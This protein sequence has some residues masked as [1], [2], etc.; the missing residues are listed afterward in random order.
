M[1]KNPYRG[2]RPG[3]KPRHKNNFKT[4]TINVSRYINKSITQEDEA[5]YQSKNSFA[6]F[7]F[8]PK[9]KQILDKI[10]Y[11]TPSEIQ[12]KTINLSL[13]GSDVIGLAN[14]GTGKT[15]AFLL[16]IIESLSRDK[17]FGRA[18]IL[19]PTREL[20]IQINQEF[21]TFTRGQKLFSATLVGGESIGQQ[22]AKIKR[23]QHV[24]IGTPGRI[25]DLI[26]RNVLRLNTVKY[27]VLD[28][29]D[30]M[31]DM[32]FVGDIKTIASSLPAD[33]QTLCFSATMTKQIKSIVQEFMTDPVTVSVIK[34]ETNNHIEQTVEYFN[35]KDHKFQLLLDH[36][37]RPNVNKTIIFS[38]TKH[39]AQRLSDKLNNQGLNAEAIHGNKSQSQ[40]RRA[41]GR[42]KSDKTDILVATDVAARGL[43]V[44]AISHVINYDEPRA[45]DDYVHR[46]GRTGRAGKEGS[47]ITY[48]AKK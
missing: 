33:H 23:G 21:E 3:F 39:G 12:D 13:A 11:K 7:A 1:N 45:Y 16:P 38:E 22:I 29:A 27:F 48:V 17:Q 14:T 5:P 41:L 46:I 42:F 36:F 6:D 8:S 15:A 37:D 26:E 18:L 44:P 47:A 30:R 25:K 9:I 32:G 43:D 28:E 35:D 4:K 40:R 2:K 31:C 19:A 10:G 20:A 24:Y 34:N